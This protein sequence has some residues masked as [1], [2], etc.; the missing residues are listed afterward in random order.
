MPAPGEQQSRP[1]G[2]GLPGQP[3]QPP[4][5]SPASTGCLPPPSQDLSCGGAQ[6]AQVSDPRV[7]A[8]FP[9]LAG[10]SESR[11][12]AGDVST[13]LPYPIYISS[14][15]CP[16][17]Y[18]LPWPLVL[19]KNLRYSGQARL[20]CPL[21]ESTSREN[22]ARGA[23]GTSSSARC[24]EVRHSLLYLAVCINHLIFSAVGFCF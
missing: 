22:A 19:P 23:P 24:P 16:F 9:E 2:P 21:R 17:P 13:V 6:L 10:S 8:H 3:V 4:I 12:S 1:Q 18:A 7:T 14:C 5:Q 15:S 20:S 11:V